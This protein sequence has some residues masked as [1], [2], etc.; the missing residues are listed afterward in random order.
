MAKVRKRR[1]LSLL[2]E[3]HDPDECRYDHNDYC[4]VHHSGEPGIEC[5]NA[6]IIAVL[7]EAGVLNG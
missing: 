7:R 4:Q 1:L 6:R 2:D 3:A 5:L